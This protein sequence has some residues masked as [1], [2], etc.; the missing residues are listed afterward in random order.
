[1]ARCTAGVSTVA[2]ARLAYVS[3]LGDPCFGGVTASFATQAD[4]ILAEPRARIGFAGGRV[5]EQATHERLPE[6]FQTAEFLLSHGMVDAVVVRS[7][8]RP[9]IGRILSAYSGATGRITRS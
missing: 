1:M 4:V 7:E 3:I 5:I 8:L 9:M 2:A 6:H